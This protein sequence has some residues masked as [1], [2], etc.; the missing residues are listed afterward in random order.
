MIKP[1]PKNQDAVELAGTKNQD[2]VLLFTTYENRKIAAILNNNVLQK[3]FVKEKVMP[4]GTIC[5]GKVSEI[6]A[7]I[8]C[9]FLMIADKQ[10]CFIQLAELKDEY[11]LTRPGQSVKCGDSFVVKITKEPAKNKLSSA[12]TFLSEEEEQYRTVGSTRTDYS[13]L[14]QGKSYID[15]AI[16]YFNILTDRVNQDS[17]IVAKPTTGNAE[18]DLQDKINQNRFRVI[19]DDSEIYDKLTQPDSVF[20]NP[21]HEFVLLQKYEDSLVGLNVLFGLKEKITE[22]LNRHVWLKSGADIYIDRTEACTVIDVNSGKSS[23][24]EAAKE[25]YLS[26]NKEAAAEICHQISL[27][28]LSGIILIDFINMNDEKDRGELIDFMKELCKINAPEMHI[29][30][31]TKLG[32]M[33]TTR[34]KT[35]PSLHEQ[36]ES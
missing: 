21:A 36:F 35:G 31:I 26:L 10:K 22:S 34:Q 7:E 19:T 20:Q 16:H 23:K 1:K 17:R 18:S 2:C 24:K 28:N 30:G 9:A 27:R 14:K 6:K 33:E 8:G 13:V 15:N 12:S 11:N 3:V 4:R 25:H 5:L 29:V 32:I